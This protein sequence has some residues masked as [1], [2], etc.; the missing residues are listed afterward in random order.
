MDVRLSA[1]R[2]VDE[3]LAGSALETVAGGDDNALPLTPDHAPMLERA[4]GGAFRRL[5]LRLAPYL[6]G[7]RTE[8]L[9]LVLPDDAQLDA[10][11]MVSLAELA[12]L[13]DVLATASVCRRPALAEMLS[14]RAEAV[15][16]GLLG[17]VCGYR[18]R[19]ARIRPG[20]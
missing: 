5:A 16:V 8:E 18:R 10:A 15:V 17:Y 9:T 2:I 12:V 20:A 3:A 13:L 4:I 6:E 11:Y 7:V 19:T 1:A 14:H